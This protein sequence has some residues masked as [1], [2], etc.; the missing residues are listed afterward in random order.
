MAGIAKEGGPVAGVTGVLSPIA[1]TTLFNKLP[2][3][4]R[5][6]KF[7]LIHLYFAI[8]WKILH[9]IRV[10]VWPWFI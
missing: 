1:L 8:Y 4:S 9:K 7:I 6:E 2:N 5:L 10:F 3:K